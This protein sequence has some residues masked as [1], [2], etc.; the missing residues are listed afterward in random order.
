MSFDRS[1]SPVRRRSRTRA[2]L[3][4]LVGDVLAVPL[5]A[6]ET[7]LSRGGW[8]SGR[9]GAS[10]ASTGRLREVLDRDRALIAAQPTLAQPTGL[11]HVATLVEEPA[12][13]KSVNESMAAPA[14][15][16]DSAAPAQLPPIAVV[17]RP[18]EGAEQV[19][20]EPIRTRTM[21]RLLAA[22]GYRARA[23]AIYQALHAECPGDVELRTEIERLQA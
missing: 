16:Q 4:Q 19:T 14:L 12:A 7:R 2:A 18:E 17:L 8:L 15:K 3:G 5:D 11:E 10:S 21:A 20:V 1:S 13:A 22:Q 9:Y 23:L 6:L